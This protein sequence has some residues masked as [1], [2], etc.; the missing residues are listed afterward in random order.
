MLSSDEDH[1]SKYNQAQA[2]RPVRPLLA[3]ALGYCR[4]PGK[5]VE[6][7]WLERS[8]EDFILL[9]FDE[10]THYGKTF[11][12]EKFWHVFTLIAQR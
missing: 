6:R 7:T 5:A 3:Q 12:G 2:D 8:L 11:T 1:W 9:Q 4:P 10:K